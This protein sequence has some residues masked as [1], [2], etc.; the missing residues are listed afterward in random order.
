VRRIFDLIS[1]TLAIFFLVLI[2][3][4]SYGKLQDALQF[5][6]RRDSEW[7]PLMHHFW[8]MTIIAGSLFILQLGKDM[9]VDLF[10][11]VTGRQLLETEQEVF[12]TKHL[13]ETE[14][15]FLAETQLC[16]TGGE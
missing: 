1:F 13:L 16:E 4:L 8:I 7:A 3:Y 10:Y 2:V 9:L 15:E 14:A 5:G 6:T 11:L 12:T